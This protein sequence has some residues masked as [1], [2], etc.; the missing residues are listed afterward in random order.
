MAI[1]RGIPVSVCRVNV[2]K[3][4]A[5]RGLSLQEAARLARY[6][7]LLAVAKRI[8]ADC[9][10]TGH[11]RD[12]RVET[13]LMRLLAG[14]GLEGLKGIP[15]KRNVT[16]KITLVRPLS[17]VSRE[18]IE[19]YCQKHQLLPL[20]DPTNQHAVYLRN[21]V[22]LR[23]LPFLEAEFGTHIKS[24]LA[25]STDLLEKD[26]DFLASL[27]AKAF[28]DTAVMPS[29][30][31]VI[32]DIAALLRLP[33]VLQSRV[34]RQALWHAGAKR[35]GRIHV[36]QLLSLAGSLSPSATC[37]LP[38]GIIARREYEKLHVGKRAVSLVDA[39]GS[40]EIKI[41]GRTYLA[42]CGLWLEVQCVKAT[43]VD[44]TSLSRNEACLDEDKITGPMM[45]RARKEGDRMQPIGA[46]GSRKVKKILA[47]RKIPR[48]KRNRVP[49]ITSGGKI[50][51]LGGVEIAEEFK[52]T[53]ETKKALF[54]TLLSDKK[55]RCK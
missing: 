39:G 3:L 42:C 15:V 4:Q 50:A 37:P 16:G 48:A 1:R 41:P 7:A 49:V 6:R 46:A 9:I 47:D 21:Q 35:P 22:R 11:H 27:G 40:T 44:I 28:A 2:K 52:V 13:L 23:L 31:E 5:A 55:G 29:N 30:N 32:L 45:A 34:I 38:G 18:E 51:W 14:G 36:E 24:T 10:A 8:G 20:W 19:D 12:D 43:D 54:L 17:D 33:V 25:R 53:S 26:A